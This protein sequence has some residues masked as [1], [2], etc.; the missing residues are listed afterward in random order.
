MDKCKAAA[1]APRRGSGAAPVPAVATAAPPASAGEAAENGSSHAA[2]SA[3]GPGPSG[4][5]NKTPGYNVAY[6]GNVAF[7]VTPDELRG[8]FK[9]CSVKLVRLHTDANTGRSKGYAHVHFE[10]EDGLDRCARCSE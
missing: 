4:R 6:V 8:V 10:D 2:R 7:E 1:A 9:D 5:A 3:A